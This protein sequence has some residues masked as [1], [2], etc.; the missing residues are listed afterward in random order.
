M[1]RE[2]YDSAVK[3]FSGRLYRYLLK[4]LRNADDASDLVQDAFEKLWVN[5]DKVEPAKAKSWLFTTAHNAFINLVKRNGRMVDIENETNASPVIGSDSRQMQAKE[6]LELCL[7]QLNEQQRSIVLLRDL[8]GY[9]YDEIGKIMN[10]N[11]S[12]VK[13]YLF[14]ARQKMKNWIKDINF[15]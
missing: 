15:T 4:N 6:I 10:L 11:E 14:R 7:A 8:E 2:E 5:R 12:Q 3:E 13:V 9:N 1:T